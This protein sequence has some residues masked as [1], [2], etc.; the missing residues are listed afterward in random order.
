MFNDLQLPKNSPSEIRKLISHITRTLS[1][2]LSSVTKPCYYLKISKY[3]RDVVYL[4]GV[5]KKIIDDFKSKIPSEYKSRKILTSDAT[6]LILYG[7]VYFLNKKQ[8]ENAKLFYLLLSLKFYG[9]LVHKYF[10]NYCNPEIWNIALD[11]VSPKH[12]F[13]TKGGIANTIIYLSDAEFEK[14]KKKFI[15]LKRKKNDD[16]EWEYLDKLVSAIRTRINQSLRSF[17]GVYYKLQQDEKFTARGEQEDEESQD[18]VGKVPDRISVSITTHGQI[19][20][21]SLGQAV[22]KSGIRVNVGIYIVKQLSVVSNREK[23]RFIL[24]LMNKIISLNDICN[25]RRRNLLVR[26]ITSGTMVQKYSPKKIILDLVKHNDKDYITDT[27]DK[28]QI[29]SFVSHYLTYYTQS[30][31]CS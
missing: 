1:R 29:V 15:S 9:S 19:N 24:L 12:N 20:K 5:D 27:I 22:S 8:Y 3:W 2:E 16:A 7:L 23:I 17:A 6:I 26:R 4:T 10:K 25:E 30:K 28:N 11:R 18:S 13:H 31:I 21:K 14:Y